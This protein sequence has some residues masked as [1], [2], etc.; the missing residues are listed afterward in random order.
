MYVPE[1]EWPACFTEF[2]RLLKPAGM[3]RITEDYTTHPGSE[4]YGGHPDAVTL[5]SPALVKRHLR[6]A[7]FHEVTDRTAATTGWH[8]WTLVQAWHGAYPKVFHVEAT[9]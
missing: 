8:D 7:G 3:I 5:T 4:R 9:R 6:D 2:H 1:N